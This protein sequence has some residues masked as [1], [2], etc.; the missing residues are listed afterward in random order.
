MDGVGSPY[1]L[2]PGGESPH[3]YSLHPSQV[4]RLHRATVVVWVSPTVES[5]LEKIMRTLSDKTRILRLIDV[6]G[7]SLLKVRDG[8]AWDDSDRGYIGTARGTG[9]IRGRF[10]GWNG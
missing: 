4:R 5:F 9:S 7:L 6:P 3:A 8:K 1:L 10:S 2:L